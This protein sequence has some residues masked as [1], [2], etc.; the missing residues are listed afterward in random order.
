LSATDTTLHA[1]SSADADDTREL[2]PPSAPA[3]VWNALPAGPTSSSDTISAAPGGAV[4]RSQ[5]VGIAWLVGLAVAAVAVA[6]LT[7]LLV[8]SRTKANHLRTNLR[9]TRSSLAHVRSDLGSTRKELKATSA[10]L[11]SS[12]KTVRSTTSQLVSMT[13]DRNAQSA[14]VKEL[15]TQL[16]GVRNSLGNANTKIEGQS[17]AIQNLKVCLDGVARALS[18]SADQYY[19]TAVD[20]L[21]SVDAECTAAEAATA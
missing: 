10:R 14:K 6:V 17:E 9:D 4:P 21:N 1:E 18:A 13:E 19:S 7:G 3:S 15:Q 8:S 2:A 20:I 12:E 11:D 16:E 5:R